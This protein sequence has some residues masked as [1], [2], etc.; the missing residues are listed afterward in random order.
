MA[1]ELQVAIQ[2]WKEAMRNMEHPP[3]F[4]PEEYEA[5]SALEELDHTEP[6][7]F[8]CRDCTV[9]FQR[10]MAQQGRCFNSKIDIQKVAL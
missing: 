1:K 9:D 7:Q 2:N 10:R 3:C 8:V 5:W 4:H 6:R